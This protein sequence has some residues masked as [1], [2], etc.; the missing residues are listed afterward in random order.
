MN[1]SGNYV[2]PSHPTCVLTACD[3]KSDIF[4]FQLKIV[5]VAVE[6]SAEGFNNQFVVLTH[7]KTGNSDAADNSGVGDAEREGAAVRGVVG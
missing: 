4:R 7:G 2:R 1:L 6:D 5:V 3:T